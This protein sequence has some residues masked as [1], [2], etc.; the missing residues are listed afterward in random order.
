LD[1]LV[2]PVVSIVLATYQRLPFLKAAIA[3]IR[4][5]QME[6]PAEIIVVEGGS[7]DGSLEWLVGQEDIL[8]IVQHNREVSESTLK[9]KRSWG[10]FTNLAFKCAQGRYICMLSDDT[11]VHPDTIANGVRRFDRELARGRALGGLA[12]Y[13]RSWPEE[14]QYR[15]CRTLGST[16]MVNHGL[17]R[18]AALE[19]VGWIEEDL[20]SFYHADSDLAFKLWHAG[21]EID[22]CEDALV[23]HFERASMQVRETNMACAESDWE[24]LK[25]RW[26]GVY[27]FPETP[28]P[29]HWAK[30]EGV[31]GRDASHLFPECAR[32]GG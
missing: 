30:L 3:S 6:F 7:S 12:F 11:V 28:D 26:T 25:A 18:R 31:T 5:S 17:F 20:Y 13:W 27:F 15:V 22:V 4:A 8:T 16:L 1:S 9:R 21:F 23:E 19:Q 29:G 32:A 24:Q 10:Y 2:R 14:T